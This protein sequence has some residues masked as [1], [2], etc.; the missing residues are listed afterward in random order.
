VINGLL[1]T[2]RSTSILGF[3]PFTGL[4][5]VNP[6]PVPQIPKLATGAVV[7][8]ATIAQIGEGRYDEAVIPLGQSPQ[9]TSMKED[10]ANAVLQGMSGLG[11]S[12]PIEITMIVEGDTFG[13]VAI[14]NIN[15]VQRQAGRTLLKV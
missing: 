7:T 5:G 10:I 4:W 14:K 1:N 8:Q 15:N 6:L 9:F 3:K 13:R 12:G 11:N 2:I